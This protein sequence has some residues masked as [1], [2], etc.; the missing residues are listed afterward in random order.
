LCGGCYYYN[1][2]KIKLTNTHTSTTI[3][4]TNKNLKFSKIITSNEGITSLGKLVN[5]NNIKLLYRYLGSSLPIS[6]FHNACDNKGST[7]LIIQTSTDAIGLYYASVS[8]DSISGYKTA[9]AGSC[10][11]C[12]FQINETSIPNI[13]LYKNNIN[14]QWSIFCNGLTGPMIGNREVAIN[15]PIN[16]SA[17]LIKTLPS[18]DILP[19][20]N[21]LPSDDILPTD[22]MV[23]YDDMVYLVPNGLFNI[24]NQSFILKAIEVFSVTSNTNL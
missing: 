9:P 5:L 23:P 22:D 21:I 24:G 11:L 14:I 6:D 12:Q 3:I 16:T 18:D 13:T 4:D 1:S 17:Y 8:W 7:L 19:S 2:K 10:W 20:D 15:V